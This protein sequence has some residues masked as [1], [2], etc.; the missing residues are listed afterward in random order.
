MRIAFLEQFVGRDQC[1]GR[2]PASG[3]VVDPA[4]PG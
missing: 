4:I 2:Q 3:K 1:V